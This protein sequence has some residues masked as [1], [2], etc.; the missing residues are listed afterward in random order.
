MKKNN[1]AQKPNEEIVIV[2]DFNSREVIVLLSCYKY[3]IY[4]Y[5]GRSFRVDLLN[6][7]EKVG[8]LVCYKGNDNNAIL[9]QLTEKGAEFVDKYFT[10]ILT[11]MSPYYTYP[12]LRRGD[13][14]EVT[15]D[16]TNKYHE[17]TGQLMK[18]VIS[19]PSGSRVLDKGLY[20]MQA[21][22]SSSVELT[23]D[24]N[25]WYRVNLS[26]ARQFLKFRPEQM[27]DEETEKSKR[28]GSIRINALVK[29]LHEHISTT[30]LA[31]LLES[32]YN[33]S[34]SRSRMVEK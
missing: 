7:M 33:L 14:I 6:K 11:E 16:I 12:I 19:G 27:E 8:K 3:G 4:L 18:R 15:Q 32:L 30:R 28:F 2:K 20:T 10:L 1:L 31:E 23:D 13:L 9:V 29:N 25:V 21:I 26:E 24:M 22:D 17:E 5:D 34:Y